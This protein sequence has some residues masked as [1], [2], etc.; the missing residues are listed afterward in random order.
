MGAS[1]WCFC[2]QL[3]CMLSSSPTTHKASPHHALS[4][5]IK[6]IQLHARP[7]QASATVPLRSGAGMRKTEAESDSGAGGQKLNRTASSTSPHQLL[8][9]SCSGCVCHFYQRRLIRVAHCAL[10]PYQCTHASPLQPAHTGILIWFIYPTSKP[11]PPGYLTY[12]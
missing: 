1:P 2:P 8:K 7:G 11:C 4:G 10:N 3:T 6:Q 5:N 12:Y 9:S